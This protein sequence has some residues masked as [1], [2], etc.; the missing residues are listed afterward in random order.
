MSIDDNNN[1]DNNDVDEI[2]AEEF[3]EA[4]QT[5]ARGTHTQK[6][7]KY[8]YVPLQA[9]E[10][11]ERVQFLKE[12][13]QDTT[14]SLE[15][16]AAQLQIPQ[17]DAERY[18]KYYIYGMIHTAADSDN[19]KR[20]RLGLNKKLLSFPVSQHITDSELVA[21]KPLVDRYGDPDTVA[22]THKQEVDATQRLMNQKIS[23]AFGFNV[24]NDGTSNNYNFSDYNPSSNGNVP[25]DNGTTNN[26]PLS[27]SGRVNLLRF[28]L[29]KVPNIHRTKIP[30]FLDLFEANEMRYMASPDALFEFM[31]NYFGPHAGKVA[32]NQFRDLITAHLKPS[33]Q[34]GQNPYWGG[35]SQYYGG[36][37]GAWGGMG[38]GA[39]GGPPKNLYA[40]IGVIP[41]GIDPRS[42]E[43]QR[44]IWEYQQEQRKKKAS[45]EMQENIKNY[46]NLK[47]MDIVDPRKQ[48]GAAGGLG[49]GD[50]MLAPLLISGALRAVPTTDEQGRPVLR[51]ESTGM[52]GQNGNG[53]EDKMLGMM[54]IMME[55]YNAV[56]AQQNQTPRFME[57]ILTTMLGKFSAQTDPFELAV[58]AKKL[59][60]T[61][62]PPGGGGI[63][64]SLEAAKI[65]L[66][67]DKMTTDRD[68]T[69]QKM[70][71]MH[72]NEM[73]ERKKQDEQEAQSSA[74]TQE[75][76]KN[77]FQI[78]GQAI[79][80]LV[81]M[82]L[83]N[84]FGG[85]A[86]PGGMF[87]GG[88]GGMQQPGGGMGM[89]PDMGMGMGNGNGN[90]NGGMGMGPS[91][92]GV[93]MPS[94]N[95]FAAEA[96]A[97]MGSPV[98]LQQV[99]RMQ[100]ASEQ[101]NP[102]WYAEPTDVVGYSPP[103]PTYQPPPPPTPAQQWANFETEPPQ[104]V[105]ESAGVPVQSTMQE[106]R[107]YTEADFENMTI[108]ELEQYRQQGEASRDSIDSF[109]NALRTAY[110]KKLY[111]GSS[112]AN[113]QPQPQPQTVQEQEEEEV[114]LP[115]ET[116]PE[117]LQQPTR[118]VLDDMTESEG[119]VPEMNTYDDLRVIPD[120]EQPK[121][122]EEEKGDVI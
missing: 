95:P 102:R 80:P 108:E 87:S 17:K 47:M 110:Q 44:L 24:S 56:L 65:L 120:T 64:Q 6:K 23:N 69:L 27:A 116:L 122:E 79:L 115:S 89:P 68:L 109:N 62:N 104:A 11:L 72:E 18:L 12:Y 28:I 90:G 34:F 86:M 83:G 112:S 73:Y 85:G 40:A 113:T 1:N 21:L 84:R 98:D 75:I 52:Q 13:A 39:P 46:V 96:P 26:K 59:A 91:P 31:T 16:V 67:R 54:R 43:A 38:F 30:D 78:G 55:M 32:F 15:Q 57:S 119:D 42:P 8:N 71:F 25:G 22:R 14:R 19:P 63:Q 97:T 10:E 3:A 58:N 81:S 105:V 106:K 114:T 20:V 121:K 9:T 117:D 41:E 94:P 103:Q 118:S 99:M 45:E 5:N 100:A 53:G 77:V 61:F 107:F 36:G 33:E 74:Q 101:G 82:F 7:P 111:G 37:G 51:Y 2:T 93:G 92:F 50:G 35:G 76:V 66:A 29:E 60:D 70:N 49:G 88:G 48:G 4:T